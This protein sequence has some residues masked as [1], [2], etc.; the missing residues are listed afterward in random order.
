MNNSERGSGMNGMER[1]SSTSMMSWQWVTGNNLE[2]WERKAIRTIDATWV[3]AVKE[4]ND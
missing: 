1:I 2:L 3:S 4:S